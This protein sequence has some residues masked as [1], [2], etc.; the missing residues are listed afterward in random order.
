MFPNPAEKHAP[1]VECARRHPRIEPD[2]ERVKRLVALKSQ[3]R[4]TTRNEAKELNGVLL[5][6]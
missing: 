4:P 5:F 3:S 6:S 1:E 2:H